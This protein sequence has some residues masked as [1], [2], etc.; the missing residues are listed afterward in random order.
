M[1]KLYFDILNGTIVNL[2]TMYVEGMHKYYIEVN[3]ND[4]RTDMR[5][6]HKQMKEIK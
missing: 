4:K 5:Y 1:T 2:N 3:F 6:M